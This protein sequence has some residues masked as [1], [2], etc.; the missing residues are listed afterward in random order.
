MEI[1]DFIPLVPT[2]VACFAAFISYKSF[3]RTLILNKQSKL[4]TFISDSDK[5]LSECF[6][7]LLNFVD[8]F[9]KTTDSEEK[10]I[11]RENVLFLQD[12]IR[13][14]YDNSIY[15]PN[16]FLEGMY[17]DLTMRISDIT[18]E[19]DFQKIMQAIGQVR[20][21]ISRLKKITST[22]KA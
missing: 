13:E 17:I 11:A 22:L 7:A 16:D 6:N 15:L 12:S 14:K 4:D 1:T 18:Y 8:K 9:S 10:Q 3:D 21:T 2:F 20:D 5:M 19:N